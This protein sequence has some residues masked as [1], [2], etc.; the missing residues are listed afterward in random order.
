MSVD[1]A[2][3]L[4]VEETVALLAGEVHATEG[5]VVSVLPDSNVAILASATVVAATVKVFE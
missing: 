5:G 1:D 3:R 2:M 4:I